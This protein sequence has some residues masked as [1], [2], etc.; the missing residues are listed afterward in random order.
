MRPLAWFLLALVIGCVAIAADA[1]A[2]NKALAETL[3]LEGKQLMEEQR[4]EEACKRFQASH[5]AE[6][7]VG[8]ILNLAL[9]HQQLGKLASAWSEYK[10]AA[11]LAERMNQPERKEGA[12]DYAAEIE[13]KLS[14]LTVRVLRPVEGL[15]VTRGG[16]PLPSGSYGVAVPV[17]PGSYLIEATAPG[18][19]PYKAEVVVGDQADRKEIAIPALDPAP[20]QGGVSFHPQTIAAFASGAVGVVS[21][22]I[23]I[24]F[25]VAALNDKDELDAQCPGRVCVTAEGQDALDQI[26]LEANVATA[27]IAIG[28]VA[29][30]GGGVLY[31]TAPRE[32]ETA[33]PGAP[34]PGRRGA[35]AVVVGL[36]PT[37]G[38]AMLVGEF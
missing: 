33:M 27:M 29:I 5:Q 14:R 15:V 18:H 26:T 7:S 11:A 35:P 3:F 30:V 1:R 16:E 21:L 22:A 38:G 32:H 24:G 37:L 13:P 4:Y 34:T 17:D 28:A 6:K 36:V 10:D 20:D 23:G 9:C 19:A 8:A 2:D 12:L 31:F 25:G